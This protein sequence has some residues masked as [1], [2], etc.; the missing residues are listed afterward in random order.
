MTTEM[1][2]GIGVVGG[3]TILAVIVVVAAVSAV[4]GG[5]VNTLNDDSENQ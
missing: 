5:V 4:L 2:I 3:L 1:M